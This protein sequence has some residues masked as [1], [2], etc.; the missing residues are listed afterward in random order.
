MPEAVRSRGRL[1]GIRLTAPIRLDETLLENLDEPREAVRDA[2]LL[3]GLNEALTYQSSAGVPG[4]WQR[5]AQEVAP[6]LR[7]HAVDA[8]AYGVLHNSDDAGNLDYLCGMEVRDFS[9]LPPSW[10]RLRVAPLRY[11]VFVHAGHVSAIRRTWFSIW[12]RWL[13]ASGCEPAG[14][15]EFERYGPGFDPHTG[16]GDI[17][18][19]LPVADRAPGAS[20]GASGDRT[21]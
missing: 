15:L 8:T 18:I 20:S 19:W 5:F 12:N 14:G 17:E 6:A 2:F 7:R 10:S 16:V 11:A 1:D 4:Q 9:G 21:P 13:P 3:A